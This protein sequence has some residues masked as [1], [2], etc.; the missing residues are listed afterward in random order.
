MMDLWR[1]VACLTQSQR[2][3]LRLCVRDKQSRAPLALP[4]CFGLVLN[5]S[6]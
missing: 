2:Q 3:A 6:G 5:R 1:K 4:N